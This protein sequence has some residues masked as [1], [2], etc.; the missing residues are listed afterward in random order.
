MKRIKL[1]IIG[2]GLAAFTAAIYAA[3][4]NLQPIVYEG[5]PSDLDEQLM[6]IENF[7]GFPEGIK[8]LELNELVRKQALRFGTKVL[9]DV[10][11]VELQ[12]RPFIVRGPEEVVH[13]DALVIAKLHVSGGEQ[14]QAHIPGSS[15][16]NIEG[17]FVAGDMCDDRYRTAIIAAATGCAAAMDAERWLSEKG[18]L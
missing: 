4:A 1:V 3:R 12:Q 10:I 14:L 15:K 16:T 7:P 17:V 8:G 5:I 11:Q 18:H 9:T 6:T 2:S 13:A